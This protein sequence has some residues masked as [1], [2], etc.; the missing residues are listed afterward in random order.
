M[1]ANQMHHDTELIFTTCV[2]MQGRQIQREGENVF[3]GGEP[4]A[5]SVQ[6]FSPSSSFR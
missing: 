2:F 4:S 1:I 6:P 3:P 5:P